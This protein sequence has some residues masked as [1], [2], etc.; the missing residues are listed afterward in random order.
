[1]IGVERVGAV[2]SALGCDEHTRTAGGSCG[3][4]GGNGG[5]ADNGV[6]R[7]RHAAD[8][9][10]GGAQQA[11]AGDGNRS[12]TGKNAARRADRC[13]RRR[14]LRGIGRIL[15]AR[16]RDIGDI[17]NLCCSSG[18]GA[19]GGRCRGQCCRID[20]NR[21]RGGTGSDLEFIGRYKAGAGD[22]YR[23]PARHRPRARTDRRDGRHGFVEIGR[24]G[25][26]GAGRGRDGD[27]DRTSGASGCGGRNRCIIH[28]VNETGCNGTKFDRGSA[29]EIRACNGY[30]GC[31]RC[32]T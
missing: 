22:G 11:G 19:G 21:H 16:A 8:G 9:N 31:T 15:L 25:D 24:I 29:R 5:G 3:G 6:A 14:I 18:P 13:H 2:G 17:D 4:G 30:R 26:I 27:T 23:L 20:N 12:A 28:N 1:M 32:R 7:H 10:T